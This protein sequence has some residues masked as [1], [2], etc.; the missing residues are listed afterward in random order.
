M[1]ATKKNLLPMNLELVMSK[2]IDVLLNEK[3][4]QH[5]TK[6]VLKNNTAK[7]FIKNKLLGSI[8]VTNKKACFQYEID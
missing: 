5:K 6:L 2:Y 1:N 3:L 4:N 8:I 7:V